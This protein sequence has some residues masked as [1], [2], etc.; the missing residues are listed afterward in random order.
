V[1]ACC[2]HFFDNYYFVARHVI[3]RVTLVQ[4]LTL[5]IVKN[6]FA[7]GVRPWM[8]LKEFAAFPRTFG[9]K[10]GR[11]KVKKN[12]RKG[13]GNEKVK[14]NKEKGVRVTE[15]GRGRRKRERDRGRTKRRGERR[16]RGREGKG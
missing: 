5:S 2:V 15:R 14:E 9:R 16:K 13:K 3:C 1:A 7:A 4:L 12:K 8:P 11:R 10:R 6:V